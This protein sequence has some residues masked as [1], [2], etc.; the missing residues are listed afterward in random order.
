MKKSFS[1]L[2]ATVLFFFSA[3]AQ[4]TVT[5]PCTGTTNPNSGRIYY[6][7]SSYTKSYGY[8]QTGVSTEYRG[9]A[10][11][12]ISAYVPA[13]ATITSAEVTFWVE[14]S[15]GTTSNNNYMRFFTGNPGSMTANAI[16]TAIGQSSAHEASS[17]DLHPTGQKIRA[18]NATGITF[19]NNNKT[20]PVNLGFSRGT[21]NFGFRI[22]GSDGAGFN[23][24]D[25]NK[26]PFLTITY[27]TPCTNPAITTQ[28]AN[29]SVCPNGAAN[30]TVAATGTNLTYQ[31]RK[32]TTPL[33]N[34]GNISGV[35]TATLTISNVSGADV[36]TD[37][38]VVIS[39]DCGSPVTSANTSVILLDP[40]PGAPAGFTNAPS[41]VCLGQSAVFTVDPVATATSYTWSYSGNG[42]T[43][44]GTGNSVTINFSNNA[45]GGTLSVAAVNSC[46]NSS[47]ITTG[48]AVN[49][50]P[51]QPGTITG[52]NN[53]CGLGN[54][55]YTIATVANTNDYTWS[56]SGGGSVSGGQGTESATIN[57]TSGGTYTVSVTANN[58]C[59]ASTP[60]TLTVNITE[61]VPTQPDNFT[62]SQSEIC[63]GTTGVVYSIPAVTGAT[64]YTWQYSGTGVTINGTGNSVTVDFALGATSGTLSVV[65]N[66]I[67]GASIER[68]VAITINTLPDAPSAF[69]TSST[70]VC[71][72]ENN[73][74]FEIPAANGATSYLWSYSGS[75]ATING[76]ATAVTINFSTTATVGE[77]SVVAENA[78]GTSASSQ[79]IQLTVNLL[80]EAPSA[81]TES[82][83][84]V[85]VGT[86][87]VTYT[88]ADVVAAT[89]Y[90]W[91]YSGSGVSINANGSTATLDFD[92]A[93]TSGTLSVAAENNCGF[94]S[95]I[96]L[97][98]SVNNVPGDI[99]AFAVAP[100]TACQ[101]ANA[102]AYQVDA[103]NSATSYKWTYDGTGVTINGTG[104]AVTLDFDNNATAGTLSVFAENS[105]G[106]SNTITT[107]ITIN[108]LPDDVANFTVSA[109]EV[110]QGENAVA[111]EVDAVVGASN[112]NW[113]YSG[114]G[115]TINGTGNTVTVDFDNTATSGTI[116]VA[117]ANSCGNSATVSLNVSV[118]N[119]PETPANLTGDNALC[120][121]A[122]ATYSVDAQSGTDFVWTL[123]SG[124]LGTSATE[125]ISATAG[126]NSGDIEVVAQNNC[127]TS[128]PAT[129]QVS[130]NASPNA[131]LGAFTTVCDDA[132]PL[133]LSGGSPIGGTYF[134]NGNAATEIDPAVLGA[135]NY[136]ITYVYEDNNGCSSEATENL[137]VDVCIGLEKLLKEK[138]TLY[139]NPA[140]NFAIIA[141]PIEIINNCIIS[142]YDA[143]GKIIDL[144]ETKQYL[145]AGKIII[146]TENYA[147]G[148]YNVQIQS[149]NEKVILT[150]AIVK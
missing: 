14:T 17:A 12:D 102:I 13:N 63:D 92:I 134:V 84:S 69:I 2:L 64:A 39:G 147:E 8:L 66:N 148:I 94:G 6:N 115:A 74:A 1:C 149:Q 133:T 101:G 68:S 137:L 52:N 138:V 42:A 83:L 54:E 48:V 91:N 129:F 99:L 79:S 72:G 98:I 95:T 50:V 117:A 103:S 71:Q 120:E 49:N 51:A 37:Y 107:N 55:N 77:V 26:R 85:C 132:D 135:G 145:E 96:T 114:N 87:N 131:T 104:N 113:V 25:I 78:C 124:W 116:S 59:G 73:V 111:F 61:T 118:N 29:A 62:A 119:I 108:T 32:G 46:G 128:Q 56:V 28:P 3:T 57:W 47:T 136:T 15:S 105:C 35:N 100:S 24:T 89:N 123:P 38:N 44:N 36:A 67:C 43:I 30:L 40:A 60:A 33:T 88:V 110:C 141:L 144:L 140:N 65:A 139:P 58:D 18:I 7:G 9:W 126:N 16:W 20:V 90:S 76:S 27:T 109:T 146:N 22:H 11:F 142:I 10:R 143:Q 106:T 86:N 45:T 53:F 21:G 125:T 130:V 80:P 121:N 19:L 4:T 34:S 82:E 112:Y 70:T 93:A 127:G 81:F 5:I 97:N 75:G 122:T 31:W 23:T 41:V 150:L